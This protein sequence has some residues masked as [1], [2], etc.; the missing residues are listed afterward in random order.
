MPIPHLKNNYKDMQSWRDDR[1][2]YFNSIVNHDPRQKNSVNGNNH[3]KPT[4]Q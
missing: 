4:Q 2:K 3:K 1:Q